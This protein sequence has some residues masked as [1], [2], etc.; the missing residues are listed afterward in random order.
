MN[1]LL[2]TH[3]PHHYIDPI[4][5]FACRPVVFS[6]KHRIATWLAEY[7]DH[8]ATPGAAFYI[9]DDFASGTGLVDHRDI[10]SVID[11]ID[12]RTFKVDYEIESPARTLNMIHAE[13]INNIMNAVVDVSPPGRY[14]C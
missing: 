8:L 10:G 5:T 14:D 13:M 6:R 4:L 11:N 3:F 12:E 7:S 1:E 9:L 2:L